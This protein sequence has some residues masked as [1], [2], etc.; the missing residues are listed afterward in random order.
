MCVKKL[1]HVQQ[2]KGSVTVVLVEWSSEQVELLLVH[3]HQEKQDKRKE[4]TGVNQERGQV[5]FQLVLEYHWQLQHMV[6]CS[7]LW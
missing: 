2:P 6:Q 5:A 4:E 3:G 1:L 7:H